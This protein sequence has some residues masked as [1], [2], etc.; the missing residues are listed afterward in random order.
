M[1]SAFSE[2]PRFA[3]A[4]AEDQEVLQRLRDDGDAPAIVREI[5]VSFRGELAEL[6]RL[7]EN[8]GDYGFEVD[9]F[10]KDDEYEGNPWLFL[11]R[12]Q[13][14]DD[15][16][17]RELTMTYL[18]IEDAFDVVSDG[19]GCMEQTGKDRSV[20]KPMARSSVENA[21]WFSKLFGKKK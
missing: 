9:S 5:D 14:A 4:W 2:H 13:A 1:T 10:E 17:M 21:G 6:T 19:W 18:Q 20:Q 12:N 3:K 16:S 7:A 11:V 15:E 8:C